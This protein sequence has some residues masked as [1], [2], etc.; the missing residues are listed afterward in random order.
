MISAENKKKLIIFLALFLGF[1]LL[2]LLSYGFV[3]VGNLV[4]GAIVASFLALALYKFEYAL[5]I[6][7][8]EI[9]V[10][11]KGYLFY[12]NFNGP[13]LSVRIAFWLIILS[14]FLYRFI[15]NWWRTGVSPLRYLSRFKPLKHFSFLFAFVIVGLLVAWFNHNELSN[16]FFD[17]NAW[18]FFAL[19]LPFYSMA[20]NETMRCDFFD[21]VKFVFIAALIYLG[22]KTLFSLFVFTHTLPF[23]G[24][25]Y[26]WLRDTGVGEVTRVGGGFFRIF[27]QSHIYAVFAFIITSSYFFSELYFES[28]LKRIW[29]FWGLMVLSA[30]M[31]VASFSR[32]FWLGLA[33]ALVGLFILFLRQG[34]NKRF[35]LTLA[36]TSS[37][38]VVGTLLVALI[39]IFPWPRPG[40]FSLSLLSDRVDLSKSEAA[41]SSRYAL[42]AELKKEI[43]SSPLLGRGL[44][45]TVTYK[46]N[47]PRLLQ[48]STDGLYTTYAFEWGFLDIWLKL[49]FIGLLAYLFLLYDIMRKK[50]SLGI[51]ASRAL[52]LT[53]VALIVVN[54][55]TPYLNHPLGIIWIILLALF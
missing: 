37:A 46:S 21:K 24:F 6:I 4:F 5:L 40:F 28:K 39:T 11:S 42:L 27:F 17:V 41:V 8:A 12:F 14:V 3:P 35:F 44:G 16:I 9:F 30:A 36:Y 31:V 25:L 10:G 49:G 23:A 54:I 7:L 33:V 1:D 50:F 22:F 32:S 47:D 19:I 48:R 45:A 26:N 55:F 18:L 15:G 2:S 51:W 34:L 13:V 43:C 53:V 38:F 20:E 52:R 29:P